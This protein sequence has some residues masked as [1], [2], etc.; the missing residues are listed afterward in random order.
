MSIIDAANIFLRNLNATEPEYSPNY[1]FIPHIVDGNV[2][3]NTTDE[4]LIGEELTKAAQQEYCKRDKK[5]KEAI[6]EAHNTIQHTSN[7][8]K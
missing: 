2:P 3:K 8:K 4:P 7:Q 5:T 6:R 1:N